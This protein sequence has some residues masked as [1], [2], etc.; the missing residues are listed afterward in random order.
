MTANEVIL[1]VFLDLGR[2]VCSVCRRFEFCMSKV[3]CPDVTA[4]TERLQ[5]T[6]SYARI[7]LSFGAPLMAALS[8]IRSTAFRVCPHVGCLIDA[9]AL[10]GFTMYVSAPIVLSNIHEH[11]TLNK[12]F[13]DRKGGDFSCFSVGADSGLSGYIQLHSSSAN[14]SHADIT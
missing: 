14:A 1:W 2:E 11:S 12:R 9:S 5:V 4:S 10:V 3:P 6:A 13:I 8:G 7:R